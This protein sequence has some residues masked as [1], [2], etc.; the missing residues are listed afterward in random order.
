MLI[1]HRFQKEVG[2]HLVGSALRIP[3]HPGLLAIFGEPGNGKTVMLREHLKLLDVEVIKLDATRLTDK[4]EGEPEKRIA[5]AY[6]EAE[7]M[8][9]DGCPAVIVIEDIDKVLG[10]HGD[11]EHSGNHHA[12]IQ[13]LMSI[14]DGT[15]RDSASHPELYVPFIATGN[16]DDNLYEPL[17]RTGRFRF[18]MWDPKKDERVDIIQS[19]FKFKHRWQAKLV[20]RHYSDKDISYFADKVERYLSEKVAHFGCR[21]CIREILENDDYRSK[22]RQQLDS[23]FADVDWLEVM[24][25]RPRIAKIQ[26]K[27]KDVDYAC[28]ST[29]DDYE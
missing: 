11:T 14:T 26:I 15:I 3:N 24:G 25:I 20:E 8:I 7:R 12:V 28:T 16:Y 9:A 27:R 13:S 21:G 18:F 23:A 17:R 19:I 6:R 1:P 29:A 10:E 4:F 2:V 22:I 5:E